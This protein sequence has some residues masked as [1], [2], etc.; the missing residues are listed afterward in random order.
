MT[1]YVGKT[2]RPAKTFTVIYRTGGTENFAWHKILEL[3]PTYEAAKVKADYEEHRG[4]PCLIFDTH[5]LDV[6]GMP[7]TY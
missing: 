4:Y 5:Q 3:Y 7:E 2:I 1:I 6:I